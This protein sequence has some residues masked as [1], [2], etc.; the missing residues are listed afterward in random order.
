VLHSRRC[1]LHLLHTLA[2]I[3]LTLAA[4]PSLL[5][6]ETAAETITDERR[7]EHIASFDQVWRT[8]LDRR[9][10]GDFDVAAWEAARDELRPRVEAAETDEAAREVIEALLMR[11]SK[12]HYGIIPREAY[13]VL[14]ADGGGSGSTGMTVRLRHGEMLVVDVREGS[15]ADDAGVEPG[16][17][18][19]SIGEAS[20][21]TILEAAQQA[22]GVQR[23]E[24]I[25]AI[26]AL[27]RLRGPEGEPVAIEAIDHDGRTRAVELVRGPAPGEPVNFGNL[28]ETRLHIESRTLEGGAGYFTL[29]AFLDPPRVMREFQSFIE[30]HRDAPGLILDMRGNMGGIVAISMGMGGWLVTERN[31][32]LGTMR[33]PGMEL[34]LVL[35]PRGRPYTGPV[36]VLIDEMSISNAELLAAGLRDIERARLFGARTAGLLLPSTVETLP[37]DDGF[38]YAIAGYDSASGESPEG[39]GVAPDERVIET[40]DSLRAGDD[41]VLRAALRWIAEQPR[42]TTQDDTP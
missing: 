17:I 21:E 20:S 1:P 9:W 13:E 32:Y 29:N 36:A 27:R 10:E 7:A 24:T 19:T 26:V 15:A 42:D 28:P 39:V 2:A 3:G 37:N 22:E 30:A 35:N 16:W 38:Q 14:E 8:V 12:S 40:P 25:V 18:I 33:F 5:A 23:L 34:R 31:L 41:P 4:A 6:Q 11:L